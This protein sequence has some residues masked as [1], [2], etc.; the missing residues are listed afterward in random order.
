VPHAVHA[1][2]ADPTRRL[3]RADISCPQAGEDGRHGLL[4][5][6]AFAL[7]DGANGRWRAQERLGQSATVKTDA[8]SGVRVMIDMERPLLVSPKGLEREMYDVGG[9]ALLSP[10]LFVA[11]L[12]DHVGS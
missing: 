5:D 3:S 7:C 10:S 11:C 2:P 6:R 12:S 1:G 9:T 8:R 4:R